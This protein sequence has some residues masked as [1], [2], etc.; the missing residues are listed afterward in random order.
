MSLNSTR[1]QIQLRIKTYGSVVTYMRAGINSFYAYKS[2]VYNGYAS[3]GNYNDVDHAV[4][5]V[6]WD[7]SKK[8]WI[9]R[10]S[11]GTSWGIGGYAYVGYNACNI[12]KYIFSVYPKKVGVAAANPTASANAATEVAS[13]ILSEN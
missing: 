11:W 5:I 4:T 13:P 12:G 8:A 6:G 3:N 10:N 2:G 9:I 7:D 1:E